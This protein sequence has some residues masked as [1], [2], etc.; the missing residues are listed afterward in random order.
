VS[1]IKNKAASTQYNSLSIL[2]CLTHYFKNFH[3]VFL[4][5]FS[6]I[7]CPLSVYVGFLFFSFLCI[8]LVIY[9]NLG[10]SEFCFLSLNLEE[11]ENLHLKQSLP[12]VVSQNSNIFTN[13]EFKEYHLQNMFDT[14]AKMTQLF[15][16]YISIKNWKKKIPFQLLYLCSYF[17]FMKGFLK[18]QPTPLHFKFSFMHIV[19][20]DFLHNFSFI[21]L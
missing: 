8:I 13:N 19:L 3:K 17:Y 2:V 10:F 12:L 14:L 18:I 6:T 7:C 16:Y 21:Y 4:I 11:D 15:M 1:V 20:F 5:S 9:F